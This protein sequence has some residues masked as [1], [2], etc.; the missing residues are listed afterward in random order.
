MISY[1]I[2]FSLKI[3]NNRFFHYICVRDIRANKYA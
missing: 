1:Y 2:F 3:D